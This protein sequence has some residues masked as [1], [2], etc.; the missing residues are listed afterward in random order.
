MPSTVSDV[1]FSEP[2]GRPNSLFQFAAAAAF[3]GLY[4]FVTVA[5]D[6]VGSG[7][8]LVMAATSV[9]SGVA[10]SLPKDRHRTAGVLRLTVVLVLAGLVVSI[11]LEPQIITG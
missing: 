1:L 8:L 6:T 7:W 3:T 9:C 2:A 4:L 5:G 10:E 11:I